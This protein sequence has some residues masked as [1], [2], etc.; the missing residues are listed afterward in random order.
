MAIIEGEDATGG[1]VVN[2]RI[3]ALAGGLDH[4]N[5]FHYSASHP[6]VKTVV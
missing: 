3:G 4:V 6:K 1:R 5:H 2:Q